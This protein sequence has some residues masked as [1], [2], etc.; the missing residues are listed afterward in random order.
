MSCFGSIQSYK[1]QNYSKLKKEAKQ[2]GN[3][4]ID[5]EF[6]PDDRSLFYT[7]AKL[8]GVVWKRPKVLN[9]LHCS[10]SLSLSLSLCLNC[11]KI[12]LSLPNHF[13]EFFFQQIC[14]NPKFF[15]EGTSSGDVRQ[16]RLG[17]CW[18]V[19]ASSCLAIHKEIWHKVGKGHEPKKRFGILSHVKAIFREISLWRPFSRRYITIKGHS[20][21]VCYV[22][23]SLLKT[24]MENWSVPKLPVY[25][26]YTWHVCTTCIII[27]D[28]IDLFTA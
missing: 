14:E 25:I 7:D 28:W 16:G 8:A 19:A 11:E 18:F 4:F 5:L 24:C 9:A 26:L 1:G 15:V 12:I 20:A 22:K 2:K 13:G 27:V 10:L 3:L 21:L 23:V 6:P 17:N